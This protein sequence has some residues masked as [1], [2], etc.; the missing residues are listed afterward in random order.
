MKTIALI[1]ILI[2]IIALALYGLGVAEVKVAGSVAPMPSDS[3]PLYLSLAGILIGTG[4]IYYSQK[5][6]R[7]YAFRSK[8]ASYASSLFGMSS[9]FMT[10]LI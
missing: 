6:P 2:P 7:K 5:A 8:M 10:L 1:G 9:V 3:T 4:G